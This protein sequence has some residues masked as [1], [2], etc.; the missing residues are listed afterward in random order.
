MAQWSRRALIS[1]GVVYAVLIWVG[2]QPLLANRGIPLLWVA[3]GFAA[4]G[5]L[6]AGKRLLPIIFIGAFIAYTVVFRQLGLSSERLLAA[7]LVFGLSAIIQA[8]LVNWLV[9]RFGRTLPPSS[10]RYTLVVCGLLALAVLPAPFLA[11]MVL[12]V[13][14]QPLVSSPPIVALQW[15]LNLVAGVWLVTPWMVLGE[16]YRQRRPMR[17]PWLWPV[18]SLLLA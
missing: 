7:A 1:F 6:L 5:V 11:V 14:Q 10:I 13:V 4:G 12:V 2:A 3:G 17:E 18:S 16:Y 8:W 9:R 15:W